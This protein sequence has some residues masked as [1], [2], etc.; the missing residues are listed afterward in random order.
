MALLGTKI[1]GKDQKTF[2]LVGDGEINEGPIWEGALFATHHRLKN[3]MMIVDEKGF[4]AMGATRGV[5]DSVSIQKKFESI[6]CKNC[7][8]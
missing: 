4:Q 3:F 6:D 7:E 8:G 2:V 5:L 1:R